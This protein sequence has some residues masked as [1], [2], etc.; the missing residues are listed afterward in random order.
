MSNKVTIIGAGSVGSTIAYTMV[1]NSIASEIVLIDI[2]ENKAIG[3]AMDIRQGVP[4]CSPASIYSGSY[5]DAKGSNVVILTSGVARKPGQS[6]LELAQIN[7]DIT[8]TIIPE[9]TKYA[10]DAIYIIVSNPIDVLTY[11]FHKFSGLPANHI[12]GS[13]TS[14]DT[15]RLRTGLSEAFDISQQNVHAYVFGEHGDSAFVP[16]SLTNIASVP[17]QEYINSLP[18]DRRKT[19]DYDAIEEYT[20]KSGGKIIANKGATFYAIAISVCHICKCLFSGA[21]TALTVSTMMNGEYGIDDVCLSVLSIV[22]RDG[23]ECKLNVPLTDEEIAKLRHSA[24]CLKEV[25]TNIKW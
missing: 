6:R 17:I 21:D 8:K 9:I 18:E 24:D 7:V 3:E 14:L 1:V 22:G 23:I 25:I 20:R 11:Q 2:N 15:S 13:G 12:I 4:Y 5:E 10:P 16:W 19:I